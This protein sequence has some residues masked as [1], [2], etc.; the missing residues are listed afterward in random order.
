[1]ENINEDKLLQKIKLLLEVRNSSK[2]LT[3]EFM[4]VLDK[5]LLELITVL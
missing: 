3:V 5:K 1:M 2:P 4:L